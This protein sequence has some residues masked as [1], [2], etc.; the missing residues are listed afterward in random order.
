MT[1]NASR[2][3]RVRPMVEGYADRH[4]SGEPIGTVLAD[5]LA[6]LMHYADVVGEPWDAIARRAER[7]HAA[8]LEESTCEWCGQGLS[9]MGSPNIDE[10]CIECTGEDYAPCSECGAMGSGPCSECGAGSTDAARE[11]GAER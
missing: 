2:A 6:D 11:I 7:N 5:M 8:E 4:D 3:A 10:L 1:S 9:E